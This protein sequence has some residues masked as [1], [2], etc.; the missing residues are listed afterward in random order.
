MGVESGSRAT[1]L[2][3]VLLQPR[4]KGSP[5]MSLVRTPP[6]SEHAALL[7]ERDELHRLACEAGRT[8]SWYVSLDTQAMTLSPMAAGLLGL[9]AQETCLA[10]DIWRSRVDSTHLR[11]LEDAVRNAAK[12]SEPFDF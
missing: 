8:G 2:T 11:G 4:R 10:A 7:R 12:D 5:I 1:P 6:A 9:P 3:A